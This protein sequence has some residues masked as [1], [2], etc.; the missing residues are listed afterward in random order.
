M[1]ICRFVLY[2]KKCSIGVRSLTVRNKKEITR[3]VCSLKI[4]IKKKNWESIEN[5]ILNNFIF[6]HLPQKCIFWPQENDEIFG[7][8]PDFTTFDHNCVL[9]YCTTTTGMGNFGSPWPEKKT[10]FPAVILIISTKTL[11]HRTRKFLNVNKNWKFIVLELFWGSLRDYKSQ[12]ESIFFDFF[13]TVFMKNRI[14][15]PSYW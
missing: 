10:H 1:F 9:H 4:F 12:R 11:H 14:F 5:W 6:D 13:F 3:L 8:R 7:K 15:L 2:T